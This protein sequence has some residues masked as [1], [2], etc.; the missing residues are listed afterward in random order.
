VIAEPPHRQVL[1]R[2][3]DNEGELFGVTFAA[4]RFTLPITD[5][6]VRKWIS[7]AGRHGRAG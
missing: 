2:L 4:A 3:V 5:A 1:G 7:R 6:S